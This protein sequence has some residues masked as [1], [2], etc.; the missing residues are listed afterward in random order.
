MYNLH[1]DHIRTA[2]GLAHLINQSADQLTICDCV[3]LLQLTNQL[4]DNYCRYL[5]SGEWVIL[6]GQ[7]PEFA[8][9]YSRER[10]R[11]KASKLTTEQWCTLLQKQPSLAKRLYKSHVIP[12]SSFSSNQWFQILHQHPQLA[13]QSKSWHNM[14]PGDLADLLKYQPQLAEHC[15]KWHLFTSLDWYDLLYQQP[16]LVSKMALWQ[17]GSLPDASWALLRAKHPQFPWPSFDQI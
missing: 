13:K 7:Y 1:P 11:R 2:M 4:P 8:K 15:R 17:H 16:Q 12:W 3:R 5:D 6:L 14:L 10:T 9:F